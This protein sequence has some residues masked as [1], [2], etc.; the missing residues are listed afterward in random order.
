MSLILYRILVICESVKVLFCYKLVKLPL[1]TVTL[2]NM[3]A[4]GLK[5]LL[6]I[7]EKQKALMVAIAW[8]FGPGS[9]GL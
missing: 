9:L 1:R 3:H 6:F 5:R 7:A 4:T 8:L 2:N